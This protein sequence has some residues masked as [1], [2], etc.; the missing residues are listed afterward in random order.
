MSK[1]QRQS[2]KRKVAIVAAILTG[3]LSYGMAIVLYGR[4]IISPWPPIVSAVAIGAASS[5]AVV[6]AW[7]KFT[8]L[9]TGACAAIHTVLS[10]GVLLCAFYSINYFGADESSSR[11]EQVEIAA[12]HKEKR[13]HSRRVGRRRYTTGQPY[14]VYKMDV[15][16]PDGRIKEL[17]TDA[18]HYQRLH[19]GSK[20]ELKLVGGRLGF[21]VVK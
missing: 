4:T 7:R 9:G 2:T 8:G 21:D 19:K 6:S 18:D 11:T 5:L 20:I 15:R 13:H 1:S 16:L 14:Y 10:A 12:L 17:S 3:I